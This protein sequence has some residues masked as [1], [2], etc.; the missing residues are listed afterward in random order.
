MKSKILY[1]N[2]DNAFTT[3]CVNGEEMYCITDE[4]LMM[5]AYLDSCNAEYKQIQSKLMKDFLAYKSVFCNDKCFFF[6]HDGKEYLVYDTVSCCFL[7]K[8]ILTNITFALNSPNVNDVVCKDNDIY[9]FLKRPAIIVIIDSISG[10]ISDTINYNNAYVSSFAVHSN[11]KEYIFFDGEEEFIIF[12]Y[13]NNKLI[14]RKMGRKIKNIQDVFLYKDIAYFLTKS[15]MIY[16]LSTNT[17][18]INMQKIDCKEDELS[19]IIVT[20]DKIWL[21]PKLGENIYFIKENTLFL[22]DNY[23]DSFCYIASKQWFD[24]G[25]KYINYIEDNEKIV[26][27][28]RKSNMV[29]LIDKLS[30]EIIWKKIDKPSSFERIRHLLSDT[31]IIHENSKDDLRNFILLQ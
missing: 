15:G 12:N 9:V 1:G 2:L 14:P 23:E 20:G 13:D 4:G 22:Y 18:N 29:C 21:F 24:V 31:K 17:L 16:L 11:G 26:F 19:I 8:A 3:F 30:E 28:L 27:P 5:H 7:K 6:S 25:S 10:N